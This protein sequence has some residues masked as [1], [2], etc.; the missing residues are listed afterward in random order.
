MLLLG[1]ALIA[2]AWFIGLV[3]I[4]IAAGEEVTKND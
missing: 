1:M 4:I 2:V 3:M